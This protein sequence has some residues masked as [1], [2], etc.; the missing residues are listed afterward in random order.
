MKKKTT[1]SDDNSSKELSLPRRSL[2]Q[3]IALISGVFF[4]GVLRLENA[5]ANYRIGT[6]TFK[7]DCCDLAKEHDP[8]CDIASCT[9]SLYWTCRH[10]NYIYRCVECYDV[11]HGLN[12]REQLT[13]CVWSNLENIKCSRS[14]HPNESDYTVFD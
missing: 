12:E 13:G 9:S 2:L 11:E 4:T 1:A 3:R 6:S 14:I 10:G 8:T 5:F 7:Q